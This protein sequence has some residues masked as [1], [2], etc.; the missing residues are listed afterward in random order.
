MD[1]RCGTEGGSPVLLPSEPP[2]PNGSLLQQA[3][4]AFGGQ[5]SH[6]AAAMEA[7]AASGQHKA[8]DAASQLPEFGPGTQQAAALDPAAQRAACRHVAAMALDAQG[9]AGIPQLGFAPLPHG[10]GD[11]EGEE[12]AGEA[13]EPAMSRSDSGGG[14]S[15]GA[16]GQSAARA[17]QALSGGVRQPAKGRRSVQVDYALWLYGVVQGKERSWCARAATAGLALYVLTSCPTHSSTMLACNVWL[18]H[19][20]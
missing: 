12:Q 8:A 20:F 2:H 5:P 17:Q 18:V 6:Q 1:G 3:Y 7:S 14:D 13:A 10:G 19:R 16:A 15:L 11:Q 9:V 4:E